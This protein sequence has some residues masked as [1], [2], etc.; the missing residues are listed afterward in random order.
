MRKPSLKGNAMA[1]TIWTVSP[2]T[3]DRKDCIASYSNRG[4]AIARIRG[5]RRQSWL[6][7]SEMEYSLQ[8]G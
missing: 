4:N 7:S 2:F 3:G 5:L 6:A 1:W 8:R